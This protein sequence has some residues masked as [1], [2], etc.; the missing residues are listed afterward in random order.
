LTRI[1]HTADWHL[2]ARLADCDRHEEHRAFLDWLLAQLGELRPQL[3]IVAG[4]IFDSATP[5][6]EALTL[7]YD[8][9]G[10]LARTVRCGVLILGGNH[11]SPATLH[12]PAPV[13]RALDVRVIATPPATPAEALWEL[14]HAVVCAVPFL[15][16]RDLCTAEPGQTAD[17]VAAAIREGVLRHYHTLHEVARTRAAGRALIATGHLATLGCTASPSERVI[18]I[19]NLGAVDAACFAG[20]AYT[21]LGHIHRAQAVGGDESVRYAGSPIPLSFTEADQPKE[22]R[23]LDAASGTVTHRA[24]E[25]P[26]FRPLRR[27]VCEAAALAEELARHAAPAGA[28]FAPWLELT[29]RDGHAHPDLERRV[30]EHSAGRAL[31]VLKLLAPPPAEAREN[32]AWAGAARS[33]ADLQPADV[34][35]E[36]LRRNGIAPDS[37]EGA[38][39][40]LTFAELLGHWQ[41]NAAAATSAAPAPAAVLSASGSG[42]AAALPAAVTAAPRA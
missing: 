29:V 31:R 37:E 34:F 26:V 19:G 12:A 1:I 3:L 38:A 36:R 28:A 2:G 6:Q 30:R 14:E 41:E 10:R 21:A 32:S 20:C 13:L 42:P 4:D 7:Y 24:V 40:T 8:F 35:A 39:L 11:D 27:V 5:P 33:L 16:Q 22:I 18:H 9:L 25:V 17:Q 23:V 15:R